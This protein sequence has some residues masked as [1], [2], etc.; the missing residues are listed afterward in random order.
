MMLRRGAL[1]GAILLLSFCVFL[2]GLGIPMPSLLSALV[3]SDI[4]EEAS[5]FEGLSLP[6]SGCCSQQFT[7]SAAVLPVFSFQPMT[8]TSTLF[9][10]PIR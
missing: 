5:M 9:R 2:L 10:P 7:V 8:F 3:P 1:Q 6:T 4:L